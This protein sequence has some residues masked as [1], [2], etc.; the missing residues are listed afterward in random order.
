MQAVVVKRDLFFGLKNLEFSI[1]SIFA[2]NETERF[3]VDFLTRIIKKTEGKEKYEDNKRKESL[4]ACLINEIAKKSH[5]CPN[6][7][8]SLPVGEKGNEEKI[9]NKAC[10]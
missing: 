10:R 7:C 6:Q 3:P 9:D 8:G 4:F 1:R 5:D 2:L